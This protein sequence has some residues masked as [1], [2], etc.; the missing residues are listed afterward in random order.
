[1]SKVHQSYFRELYP[2]N[3]S[4]QQEFRHEAEES[5]VAQ[6]RIEA[7][8]RLSFDQYLQQYFST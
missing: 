2:P 6:S 7:A 3:E 4:R 1:M 5:L 8:D